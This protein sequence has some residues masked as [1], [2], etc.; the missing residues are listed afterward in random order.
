MTDVQDREAEV[1]RALRRKGMLMTLSF[2]GAA[3]VLAAAGS[4]LVAWMLS[5][6]GMPF[7]RTWL[8]CM[9]LLTVPAAV[10]G[11]YKHFR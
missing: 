11:A 9:A 6:Q 1:R 3:L 10:A 8:V 2:L 5:T 7:R 4:A